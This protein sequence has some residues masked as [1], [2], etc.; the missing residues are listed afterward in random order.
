[1]LIPS[2]NQE[3]VNPPVLKRKSVNKRS[4]FILWAFYFFPQH[5]GLKDSS[6]YQTSISK[7]PGER[8]TTTAAALRALDQNQSPT[9]CTS[10]LR[11]AYKTAPETYIH[12]SYTIKHA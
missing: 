1:M 9:S 7:R 5:V 12:F 6:I 3:G 2:G 11:R 4:P 8:V 10:M